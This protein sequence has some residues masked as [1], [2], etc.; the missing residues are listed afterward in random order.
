[1]A[2]NPKSIYFSR[3]IRL[4]MGLGI[5]GAL[6]SACS[7]T[8]SPATESALRSKSVAPKDLGAG[9]AGAGF[10]IRTT[11][12]IPCITNGCNGREPPGNAYEVMDINRITGAT[13]DESVAWFSNPATAFDAIRRNAPRISQ[14]VGTPLLKV[15]RIGSANQLGL[16]YSY[17]HLPTYNLD[18]FVQE[19]GYIGYFVYTG[20]KSGDAAMKIAVKRFSQS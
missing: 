10:N 8:T 11:I 19:H 12:P 18:Y 5:V 4:S 1:V 16:A 15:P 6:F 13:F 7:S 17:P 20:P 2:V 3:L 14:E 9:W